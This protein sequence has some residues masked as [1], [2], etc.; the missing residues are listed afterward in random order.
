[1]K[2]LGNARNVLNGASVS[3]AAGAGAFQSFLIDKYNALSKFTDTEKAA[4]SNIASFFTVV[5]A[6]L[7]LM[8]ILRRALD[9]SRTFR[10]IFLG[11]D[12]IEGAWVDIVYDQF[13]QKIVGGGLLYIF[14]REE[15]MTVK[16]ETFNYDG[17]AGGQ[18]LSTS[19]NYDDDSQ[20]I[21]F[22]YSI[23]LDREEIS[24]EDGL[25]SY[26]FHSNGIRAPQA[27]WGYFYAS[28]TTNRFEVYGER[29]SAEAE[30]Q[31]LNAPLAERGQFVAKFIADNGHL[32]IPQEWRHVGRTEEPQKESLL[33]QW[34]SFRS[35]RKA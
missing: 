6:A 14:L 22:V 13:R 20:K 26:S 35:R 10:K 19:S 33:L 29:I 28:G 24:Q 31:L 8:F 34:L 16:G 32:I 15:R 7:L 21:D 23:N 27:F 4:Y 9:S 1:M 17:T 25:G 18:F 5:A 3:I 11:S 12:Y 30:R 2:K